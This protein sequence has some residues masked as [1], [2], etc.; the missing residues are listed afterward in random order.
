MV[1]NNKCNETTLK[2]NELL[3][4]LN[5]MGV[6]LQKKIISNVTIYR[7]QFLGVD[8]IPYILNIEQSGKKILMQIYKHNSN[9]KIFEVTYLSERERYLKKV[10]KLLGKNK[11]R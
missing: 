6:L 11:Q 10:A 9:T 1:T 7:G 8:G 4:K 3:K 5:Q 2:I